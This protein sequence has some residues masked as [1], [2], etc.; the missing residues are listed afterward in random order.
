M[1]PPLSPRAPFWPRKL[2]LGTTALALVLTG[3]AGGAAPQS[4]PVVTET[5]GGIDTQSELESSSSDGA[6]IGDVTIPAGARAASVDLPFPVPEDWEELEGFAPM[7]SGAKSGMSGMLRFSGDARTAA[8][9]YMDLLNAAGF[10]ADNYLPGE[11]GNDASLYADGKINGQL[12]GALINFDTDAAGTQR[13][14][15]MLFEDND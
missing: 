1:R 5:D 10:P 14:I 12:Y 15:I 13:A 7:E 4:P 2:V 9:H 8:D 3:C 6:P 11:T